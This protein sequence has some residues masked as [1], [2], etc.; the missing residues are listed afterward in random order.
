M[1]GVATFS[2]RFRFLGCARNDKSLNLNDKSVNLSDTSVNPF[3]SRG[4]AMGTSLSEQ[5]LITGGRPHPRIEY[6]AGSEL[7]EGQCSKG[8]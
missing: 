7:V 3:D 2:N 8:I 6:G 1:Y 5:A 4:A